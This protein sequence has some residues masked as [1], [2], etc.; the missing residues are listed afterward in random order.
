[1]EDIV[2]SSIDGDSVPGWDGTYK[3]KELSQES[4]I[5]NVKGKLTT[6]EDLKVNGGKNSGSVIIMN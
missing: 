2:E 6:G 3:G 5:W 1:V 4:F